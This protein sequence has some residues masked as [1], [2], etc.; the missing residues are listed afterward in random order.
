LDLATKDDN[1]AYHNW[2]HTPFLGPAAWQIIYLETS[3]ITLVLGR[4]GIPKA[5]IILFRDP[6]DN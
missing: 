4:D 1:V 6:E 5:S 3:G 2:L